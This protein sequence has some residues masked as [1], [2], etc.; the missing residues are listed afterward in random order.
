MINLELENQ[1]ITRINQRKSLCAEIIIIIVKKET[2]NFFFAFFREKKIIIKATIIDKIKITEL[3]NFVRL[4]HVDPIGIIEL[5]VRIETFSGFFF[6]CL[7][8]LLL[9]LN[10]SFFIRSRSMNINDANSR[11]HTMSLVAV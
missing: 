9:F 4:I 5:S 10:N 6:D 7:S 2:Q 11:L 8:L 3:I 1:I